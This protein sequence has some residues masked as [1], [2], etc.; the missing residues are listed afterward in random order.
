MLCYLFNCG[1]GLEIGFV[2]CVLAVFVEVFGIYKQYAE[3]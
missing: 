2:C 1:T 3:N